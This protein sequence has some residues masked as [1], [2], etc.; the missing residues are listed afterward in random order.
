ML[1][2]FAPLGP[3]PRDALAIAHKWLDAIERPI[4]S[5]IWGRV[6]PHIRTSAPRIHGPKP[7]HTR[8][9][10]IVTGARLR[11]ALR[12]KDLRTREAKLAQ[13]LDALIA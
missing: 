6:A 12:D 10:R 11:K 2:V 7:K 9:H 1:D 8:L 4:L 3:P 5:I 13:N